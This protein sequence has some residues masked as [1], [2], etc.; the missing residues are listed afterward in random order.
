MNCSPRRSLRGLR[1]TA[2]A[3]VLLAAVV[4]GCPVP[5]TPQTNN[6]NNTNTNSQGSQTGGVSNT[7][8]NTI[9]RPIP[10][11]PIDVNVN[12]NT[13]GGAGT[14]NS[15]DFAQPIAIAITQPAGFDIN[16][17]PGGDGVVTYETAGGDPADGP[18]AVELFYDVDG[19]P[20]SGDEVTLLTGLA[21]RGSQRFTANLAP[22]VYRVGVKAANKKENRIVYATGRLVVVGVPAVQVV[23]PNG[24]LR[25]RPNSTFQAQISIQSLASSVSYDVLIDPDTTINGNERKV[26]TGA[27]LG[28]SVTVVTDG[29]AAGDYFLAIAAKD[30]VGQSKTEYNRTPQGQFRKLTIDLA[31]SL[32]VLSPTAFDPANPAPFEVR[33]RAS[34]PEGNATVRIF[35][36]GDAGFNGNEVVLETF[37]ITTPG[38]QEFAINID[39]AN[40]TPGTYRFGGT[41]SDGVGE[42]IFSYSPIPVPRNG[43]PIITM[44]L[45]AVQTS[46]VYGSTFELR[47]NARDFEDRAL[48]GFRILYAE[49]ADNDGQPDTPPA[50]IQG[51]FGPI[52]LPGSAASFIFDT[53]GVPGVFTTIN[54]AGATRV[55]IGI[56]AIDDLGATTDALA[57]A[58]VSVEQPACCFPDGSCST[59]LAPGICETFGGCRVGGLTTPCSLVQCRV[60]TACTFPPPIGQ[61]FTVPLDFCENFPGTT[62]TGPAT[63]CDENDP[64][65]AI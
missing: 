45:P 48:A 56:R 62:N 6:N 5:Q 23:Q 1:V 10:P 28:G 63:L 60:L 22:G 40:L 61:C 26:F 54:P 8:S 65:S 31:P 35:R 29:L 50:P 4:G 21:P 39:P 41:V 58:R 49:D 37:Q 64:C 16:V 42:P 55:V 27:G 13:G 33:V 11:V 19:V 46:I 43:P 2:A 47:W 30:S 38:D 32:S 7:N 24:D 18:I 17:A 53:D 44:T 15:S 9:Q 36:D 3:G 12:S 34:D 59:D 57:P 25:V 51:P 20:R 14:P 52:T